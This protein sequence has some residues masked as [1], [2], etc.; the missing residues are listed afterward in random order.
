M[1][2]Y[3]EFSAY[4]EQIF[5]FRQKTFD[6]LK[7]YL[8]SGAKRI[9]DLG[10]GSGHYCGNFAQMGFEATGIDLDIDM[11]NT[12]KGKY[13]KVDFQCFDIRDISQVAKRYDLIFCIG[14]VAA[15]ITK[16]QF[17]ELI[18][19]LKNNLVNGGI[20]I[21]QVK[22]WDYILKQKRYQFPQ[23]YIK[24]SGLRFH[25]EYSKISN[26]EITFETLL[27]SNERTIFKDSVAL[28]PVA[29]DEYL[30]IHKNFGYELVGFY[31]DFTKAAYVK[32]KDLAG[33]YVFTL[34]K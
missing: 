32:D 22:N 1:S 9:L 29:S 12:A 20:W 34:R 3:A 11:I 5:P 18:I 26:K 30:E 7:A 8:S 13:P 16:K 15:H 10:C 6:F 28:Y 25:R 14:N 24:E 23:I 21:F 4:Y 19:K 27:K 31:S 33:I 17:E 2:F